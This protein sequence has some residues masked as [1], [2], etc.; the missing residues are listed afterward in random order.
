MNASAIG[1]PS[2]SE[3][4]RDLRSAAYF[5]DRRVALLKHYRWVYESF[6]KAVLFDERQDALRFGHFFISAF[7]DWHTTA[8]VASVRAL[9]EKNK[10]S[11][12]LYGVLERVKRA[13]KFG[14]ITVPDTS[15]IEK[16]QEALVLEGKQLYAY[17]SQYVVHH[18][19]VPQAQSIDNF[20]VDRVIDHIDG[21]LGSYW[22]VIFYNDRPR[23]V[24][25]ADPFLG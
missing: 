9:V 19:P 24:V 23:L 21:V 14:C 18:D 16:D 7:A 20:E 22:C 11:L 13:V 15:V 2:P 12:N 3:V 6:R 17:V 1:P 25:D 10:W 5:V 8:A 4:L